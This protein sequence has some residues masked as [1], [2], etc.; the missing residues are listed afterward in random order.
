VPSSVYIRFWTIDNPSVLQV[1]VSLSEIDTSPVVQFVHRFG[2][3]PHW[4]WSTLFS[5]LV[6]NPA[7]LRT[8]LQQYPDRI[9]ESRV[10]W[11]SSFR[12]WPS[13]QRV[14][15]N[16]QIPEFK[17]MEIMRVY[18][19]FGM[20]PRLSHLAAHLWSM[21][22]WQLTRL[23]LRTCD[24]AR[25]EE[26]VVNRTDLHAGNILHHISSSVNHINI[27]LRRVLRL[28]NP[29]IH[30]CDAL[31][32]LD[33][34]FEVL[35]TVISPRMNVDEL[36]KPKERHGHGKSALALAVLS[37][38]VVEIDWIDLHRNEESPKPKVECHFRM[39]PTL[40]AWGADPLQ[41]LGSGV[42]PLSLAANGD[43]FV[44]EVVFQ[45]VTSRLLLEH[46][47]AKCREQN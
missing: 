44:L 15:L 26:L 19:D 28:C 7:T 32:Y 2:N 17:I 37:A 42:T 46:I 43:V 45:L 9:A 21:R 11:E 39:I 35:E 12:S 47:V 18:E 29:D 23:M 13:S 25:W 24:M 31:P 4:L 22:C 40:L 5:Q 30:N 27:G 20:R 1:C 34:P 36:T 41:D 33:I 14:G 10:Y 16:D 38:T 8:I 6:V 3:N